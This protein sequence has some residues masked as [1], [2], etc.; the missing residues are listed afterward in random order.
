[1]STMAVRPDD[2]RRYW[3]L[4]PAG[5]RQVWIEALPEDG[6]M[7]D[8]FMGPAVAIVPSPPAV[9]EPWV[10]DRLCSETILTVWG[11]EPFPVP[12]DGSYALCADHFES[13][14]GNR[15]WPSRMCGCGA[16]LAQAKRWHSQLWKAYRQLRQEVIAQN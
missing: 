16:C 1:M 2:Q 5:H 4:D 6:E 14:R 7:I 3:I 8:S 9:D 10:C 13:V 15:L 12:S 11:G